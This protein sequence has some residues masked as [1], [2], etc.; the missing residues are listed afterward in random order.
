MSITE[1]LRGYYGLVIGFL[2]SLF[3]LMGSNGELYKLGHVILVGWAGNPKPYGSEGMLE[4]REFF[5][6]GGQTVVWLR[7]IERVAHLV[8]RE[9]E[10][11]WIVN[12]RVD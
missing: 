11:N 7:A 9:P 1:S 10:R 3:T 6:G 5:Y 8:P 2:N 4:V 12:N